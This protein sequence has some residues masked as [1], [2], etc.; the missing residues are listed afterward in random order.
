MTTLYALLKSL[1]DPVVFVLIM[2]IVGFLVSFRTGRTGKK[3]SIRIIILAAFSFLY[4]A[5]ISPVPNA[6]SYI[7]EREYLLGHGDNMGKLNII[8]VLGGGVSE[9]KYTGTKLPSKQTASRLL[10][11]VQVFRDSGAKYLVCAGKGTGRISEA[12]VM[13]NAAERLG[14]PPTSIKIDPDSENT[15]EHAENLNEMLHDK[16]IRIGLVTSAYHMKRSER[17]FRKY[18]SYVIPL[19]SDYLYSS[20]SLSIITFLPRSGNLH[21]FSIALREMIG[22][23]WYRIKE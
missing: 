5:S 13:G 8:V 21:K 23:A 17:E 20:S 6:L 7:L 11:A 3:Q 14:I 18:F 16:S 12:E 22:I 1:L 10:Y 9:N 15:W 19:P 4:L 2:I